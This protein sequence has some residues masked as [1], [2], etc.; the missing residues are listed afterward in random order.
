MAVGEEMPV[1]EAMPV[2]EETARQAW[3]GRDRYG[4]SMAVCDGFDDLVVR[5]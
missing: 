4:G 5:R 2:G 3:A 1:G